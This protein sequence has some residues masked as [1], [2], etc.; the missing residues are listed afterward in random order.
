MS[1]EFILIVLST[2]GPVIVSAIGVKISGGF[3]KDEMLNLQIP[4][5]E[6]SKPKTIDV[7]IS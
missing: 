1:Q 5:T 3:F 4:K 7:K 6:A 2:V